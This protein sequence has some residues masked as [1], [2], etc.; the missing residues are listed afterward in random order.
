MLHEV[1]V[2]RRRVPEVLVEQHEADG[3]RVRARMDEVGRSLLAEFVVEPAVSEN[4]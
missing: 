2:G 3:M 4:S 1:V